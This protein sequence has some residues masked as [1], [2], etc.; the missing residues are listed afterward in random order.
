MKKY[1]NGYYSNNFTNYKKN[2]IKKMERYDILSGYIWIY[3][4]AQVSNH[5]IVLKIY[6]YVSISFKNACKIKEP[7][8]LAI[9]NSCIAKT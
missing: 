9:N 7:D 5:M 2:I 1:C 6:N 4:P 8:M 3:N